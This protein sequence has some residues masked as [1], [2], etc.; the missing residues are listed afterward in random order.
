[1]T[2]ADCQRRLSIFLTHLPEGAKVILA[3]RAPMPAW[4]KP[5]YA[6]DRMRVFSQDF[7]NFTPEE[8]AQFLMDRGLFPDAKVL[9]V[10]MKASLGWI[11]RCR[12]IRCVCRRIRASA[13]TS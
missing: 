11:W 4:L 5:H 9:D 10:I 12:C 3:G 13:W 7:L 2:D 8:T 1:M 6:A